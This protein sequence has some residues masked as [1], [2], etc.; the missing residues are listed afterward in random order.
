MNP[1]EHILVVEDID[2]T[3]EFMRL[4]LETN[5]YRVSCAGNGREALDHLHAGKRPSLILLDLNMPV[6]DG[7][8]FRHEQR[9]NPGL[10][11]IPVFLLSGEADL[12]RIAAGLRVEGYYSKPFEV[13]GLL[14]DIGVLVE[15]DFHHLI[16]FR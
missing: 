10:A 1:R 13:E 14:Q 11:S 4:I 15:P 9:H 8:E 5:G 2:G 16:G 12:P 7:W 3:R 6:M